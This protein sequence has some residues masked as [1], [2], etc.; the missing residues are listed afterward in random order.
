MRFPRSGVLEEFAGF[1]EPVEGGVIRR[2]RGRMAILAGSQVRTTQPQPPHLV[3][4]A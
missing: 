2:A 1:K 3:D 4:V